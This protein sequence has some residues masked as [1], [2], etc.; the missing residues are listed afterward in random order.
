VL[1]L[2]S[3]ISDEKP[4]TELVSGESKYE[5]M[6]LKVG[7]T[8]GFRREADEKCALLGYYSASSVNFLQTFQDNLSVPFSRVNR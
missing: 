2:S 8:W 5:T 7:V 4:N 3:N 6:T 1:K